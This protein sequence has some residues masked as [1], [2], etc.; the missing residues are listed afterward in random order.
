MP[1]RASGS[2][3]DAGPGEYFGGVSRQRMDG[4][5]DSRVARFR[6]RSPALL[7]EK[8]VAARL[9]ACAD[10]TRSWGSWW[11]IETPGVLRF[12]AR[13]YAGIAHQRRP[14]ECRRARSAG[15]QLGRF[16]LPRAACCPPSADLRSRTRY[17]QAAVP[18][19]PKDLQ[20]QDSETCQAAWSAI[21]GFTERARRTGRDSDGKQLPE[22]FARC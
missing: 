16:F 6:A 10:R 1:G 13:R 15:D 12:R 18:L 21:P 3:C 22:I 8:K 4:E 14:A 20:Q 19:A 9:C 17:L 2:K 5:H 7:P 11:K